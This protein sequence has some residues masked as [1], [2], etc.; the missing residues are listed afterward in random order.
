MRFVLLLVLLPGLL[1]I[2]SAVALA[3]GTTE[4]GFESISI[5]TN[6]TSSGDIEIDEIEMLVYDPYDFHYEEQSIPSHKID[7]VGGV[8]VALKV[9][10]TVVD[11][12]GA[13]PKS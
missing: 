6:A 11:D 7:S 5:D 10:V 2:A 1:A 4:Y 9:T 13:A 3:D 8:E 12:T